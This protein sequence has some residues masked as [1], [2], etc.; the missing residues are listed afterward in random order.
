MHAQVQ[1]F[2]KRTAPKHK[3][4]VQSNR[5]CT[6]IQKIFIHI[7]GAKYITKDLQPQ[8]TIIPDEF[9]RRNLESAPAP[10]TA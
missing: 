9:G 7:A 2:V 6:Y 8:D 5:P 10:R 3:R 1:Y 4:Q